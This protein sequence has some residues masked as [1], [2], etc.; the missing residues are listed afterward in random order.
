MHGACLFARAGRPRM[1]AIQ[2]GRPLLAAV[3]GVRLAFTPRYGMHMQCMAPG[4]LV[5]L[6]TRH[7]GPLSGRALLKALLCHGMGLGVGVGGLVP[8]GL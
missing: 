8:A 3:P 2:Q 1:A 4:H 6:G 7:N 5:L